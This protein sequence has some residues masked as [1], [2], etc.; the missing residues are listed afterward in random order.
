MTWLADGNVLVALA[1]RTHLHH[2]RAHQWLAGLKNDRFATCPITQSTLLRVHMRVSTE[3]TAAAAWEALRA[4]SEHPGHEWW[5]EPLNYLDVPH[6]NL[7]GY[8]QVTDAW[9]AELARR[10]GGRV[11]T[12]DSGFAILHADVAVLLPR[13]NSTC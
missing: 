3:G 6:R 4:A 11:A 5:D 13:M 9:L 12:L 1:L 10:R 2:E 8:R 7:Q